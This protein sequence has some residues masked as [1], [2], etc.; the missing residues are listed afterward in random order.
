MCKCIGLSSLKAGTLV[1]Y[2]HRHSTTFVCVCVSVSLCLCICEATEPLK[3]S[4]IACVCV[5]CAT[6]TVIIFHY[7]TLTEQFS[8]IVALL[9][10][11][12]THTQTHTSQQ[13]ECISIRCPRSHAPHTTITPPLCTE[14]WLPLTLMNTENTEIEIKS[15]FFFSLS[16]SL[17]RVS[18]SHLIAVE[19]AFI[20]YSDRNML[21]FVPF[22]NN[23]FYIY[24]RLFI[25]L[26]CFIL[27]QEIV[28][29]TN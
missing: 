11:T 13:S 18:S 26:C 16:L 29:G 19:Q 22:F 17:A 2:Q 25:Y 7:T 10:A 8:A 4:Q 21:L 9:T 1:S 20:S 27:W 12:H 6:L 23:F 15:L 5:F 3:H 28:R 24:I 14:L